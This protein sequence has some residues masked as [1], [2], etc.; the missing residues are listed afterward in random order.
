VKGL[1]IIGGLGP[2][3][4]ILA[5]CGAGTDVVVAA[6]S[7][8]SAAVEAGIDPDYVV[9]DMDS[10]AD[11]VL[12]EKFPKVR[13]RILPADKDETDTEYGLRFLRELGCTDIL[14]AGG[15]GGRLD[16]C[17][18]L[19]MLFERKDPPRRWITEKEDVLLIEGIVE[20]DGRIGETLSVFPLGDGAECMRSTGLKW[21]LDGLCFPRG[22]GGISNR[23]TAERVSI[24]VE[25][26]RL[27]MVK[28]YGGGP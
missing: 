13:T 18:A 15:G 10:L 19:A 25:K 24:G 4:R 7:G 14:I 2:A 12:L 26:G 21:P 9:G 22:Y 20:F 8:L 6:D 23:I 16:H 3:P 27:L 28:T 5:G 17:L 11:P 1:L